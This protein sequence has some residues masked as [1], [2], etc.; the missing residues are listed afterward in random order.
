MHP[1]E[2][3]LYFS[4]ILVHWIVPS[5]PLVAM[6]HVFHAG[7]APTA[8]HTGYEKMTFKNGISIPTG[9]YN[10]YL[11]HKYFECNYG[12]GNLPLDRWFGTLHD[13]SD[14]AQERMI[15]RMKERRG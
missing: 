12:D 10:H 4:G 6:F 1:I 2:H 11:H 9:D 3:L 7:I 8:G 15:K 14:E 5:H 13:G